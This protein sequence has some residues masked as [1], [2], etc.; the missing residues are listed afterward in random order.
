MF[1]SYAF[2]RL[3][4]WGKEKNLIQTIRSWKPFDFNYL[5]CSIH[6]H[7]MVQHVPLGAHYIS[8]SAQ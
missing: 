8:V 2:E 1:H 5:V 6:S 7:C 4:I 3:E